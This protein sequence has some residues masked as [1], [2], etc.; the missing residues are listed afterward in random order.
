VRL[1]EILNRNKQPS[2]KSRARTRLG[3]HSS[4]FSGDLSR[5]ARSFRNGGSIKHSWSSKRVFLS[6]SRYMSGRQC[7]KKLWQT[8]YDPEPANMPDDDRLCHGD[9]H[10]LNVLG[11]ASQPFVIDWPDAC[12]GERCSGNRVSARRRSKTAIVCAPDGPPLL[13]LPRSHPG[14]QRPIDLFERRALLN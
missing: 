5:L 12:R 2:D 3:L 9:F 10:P 6:K 7:S 11:E 8:V 13:R 1:S 4:S 14:L